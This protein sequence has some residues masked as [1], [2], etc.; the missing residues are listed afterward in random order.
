MMLKLPITKL[1]GEFQTSASIESYLRRAL[2]E[3]K[4]D[5][6]LDLSIIRLEKCRRGS[7]INAGKILFKRYFKDV[8]FHPDESQYLSCQTNGKI[9]YW[10]A[11]D[12][13]AIR[14]VD[15]GAA[16]MTCLDIEPE[17]N[18]FVSGSAD[19]SVRI[20]NYDDGI[21]VGIGK[22]HSGKVSSVAISPD[23]KSLVSVGTEGGIFIWD[24]SHVM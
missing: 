3:I 8:L 15:G 21:T 12:G 24:L 1:L 6:F 22:G 11:Y 7:G 20:W 10:D 19:K 17:G 23:Q 9:S 14:I 5:E 13:S 2:A 4:L 18:I 16:D